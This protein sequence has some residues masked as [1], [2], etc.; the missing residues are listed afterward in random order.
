M[1]LSENSR[2]VRRARVSLTDFLDSEQAAALKAFAGCQTNAVS[3]S[4][5]EDCRSNKYRL[6]FTKEASKI[7]F[8][9][10]YKWYV[11]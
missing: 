1:I 4:C 5:P 6:I 7:I 10:V 11:Q 9:K 2:R 8:F 3:R